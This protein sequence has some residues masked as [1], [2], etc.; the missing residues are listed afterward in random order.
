MMAQ[1]SAA[2]QRR[3]TPKHFHRPYPVTNEEYA[4]FLAANPEIEK[5]SE[6][7]NRAF[8]SARQPVVG[9]TWDDA[10]LFAEWVG[11]RLATEAEWEYAARAGTHAPFLDGATEEGLTRDGVPFL[12]FSVR[13]E[14]KRAS[15]RRPRH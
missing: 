12:G 14:A 2:C 10:R 15:A 7:G 9:V 11:C 13:P 4:R 6:W 3:A 8:N 1:G 5:P